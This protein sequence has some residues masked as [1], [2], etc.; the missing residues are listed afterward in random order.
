MKFQMLLPHPPDQ[1]HTF[2]EIIDWDFFFTLVK[3]AC[4]CVCVGGV[5]T[6]M[7]RRTEKGGGI[8][9]KASD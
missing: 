4:V 6:H 5:C 3:N 9:L 8:V 2:T 1:A 7:H